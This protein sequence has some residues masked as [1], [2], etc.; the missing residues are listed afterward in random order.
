MK[1]TKKFE[2]IDATCI[3]SMITNRLVSVK[4]KT[5]IFSYESSLTL[6]CLLSTK[7]SHIFKQT[8]GY[9]LQV[10]LSMYDLLV[11]T[12]HWRVKR[13]QI[14]EHFPDPKISVRYKRS[15]LM[16]KNLL[17]IYWKIYQNADRVAPRSFW[18]GF[19]WHNISWILKIA[20]FNNQFLWKMFFG[21]LLLKDVIKFSFGFFKGLTD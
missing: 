9:Q 20:V 17:E 2:Y 10:C 7:K 21:I 11:D 5:C 15:F 8:Y 4:C 1:N 14:L 16:G 6:K 19:F 13:L 3:T 12:W 18:T